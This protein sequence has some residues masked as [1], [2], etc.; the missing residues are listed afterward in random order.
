MSPDEPVLPSNV[1]SSE[2]LSHERFLSL[3]RLTLA[4]ATKVW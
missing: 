4:P 2:L 1:I 3:R